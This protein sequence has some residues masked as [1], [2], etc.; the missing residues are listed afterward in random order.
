MV[1]RVLE[2]ENLRNIRDVGGWKTVDGKTVKQGLLYRGCELDGATVKNC[3]ITPVGENI[4]VDDLKIMT[5]LDL[6][7]KLANTRDTLGAKVAHRYFDLPSYAGCFTDEGNK[8]L[9]EVFAALAEPA[10]YPVYLHCTNGADRTGIVCYLLEALLGMS[11]ADC[12]RD[13]ELSLLAT[14]SGK[15][16]QMNRFVEALHQVDGDTLQA[17]TENY[18]L[19]IGVAQ[20]QIEA[21]RGILVG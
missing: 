20:A 5:E 11:E 6:R 17:K 7:P 12:Y 10:N 3:Q 19:S 9:A 4:M 15:Y 13:W 1:S 8:K 14:G 2:F 16:E 21:I 18:L